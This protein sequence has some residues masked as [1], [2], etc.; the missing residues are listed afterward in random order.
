[1]TTWIQDTLPGM[2]F[3]AG[4]YDVRDSDNLFNEDEWTAGEPCD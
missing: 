2:E 4:D 1:V 3:L